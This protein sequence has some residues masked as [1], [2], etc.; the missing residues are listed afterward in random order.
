M[1]KECGCEIIHSVKFLGLY[2]T[3]NNQVTY[4][5][6]YGRLWQEIKIAFEK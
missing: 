2:F 4:Q 6:N 3:G 5:N 1:Q